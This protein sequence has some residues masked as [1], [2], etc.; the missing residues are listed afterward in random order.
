MEGLDLFFPHP[1]YKEL[2]LKD[3]DLSQY[4]PINKYIDSCK[5]K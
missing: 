1:E 5:I 3:S 4:I 2:Y